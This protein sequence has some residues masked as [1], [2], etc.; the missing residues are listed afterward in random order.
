MIQPY[1]EI[2]SA[3]EPDLFA[4]NFEKEREESH[5]ILY[6][7]RDGCGL[8]VSVERFGDDFSVVLT[9]TG[10]GERGRFHALFL[11]E[12]IDPDSASRALATSKMTGDPAKRAIEWWKVFLDFLRHYQQVVFQSPLPEPF[13]SRYL[14]VCKQRMREM[15][16]PMGADWEA[17]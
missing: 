7:R 17:R 12:A 4:L 6:T 11:M 9:R 1:N 10:M 8:S 16:L 2:M 3:V 5:R 14:A 15:G 13:A